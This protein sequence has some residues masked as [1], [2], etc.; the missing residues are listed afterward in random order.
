MQVKKHFLLKLVFAVVNGDRV[1]VTI[2]TVNEGLM[3][4][5]L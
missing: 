2:E 1:V 5:Y 3:S 4:E